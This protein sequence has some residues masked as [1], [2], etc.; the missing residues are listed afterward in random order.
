ML[1]LMLLSRMSTELIVHLREQH[2]IT[3]RLHPKAI[4]LNRFYRI[5]SKQTTVKIFT[6]CLRIDIEYKTLGIQWNTTSK[7]VVGQLLRR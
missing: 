7:D 1:T 6:A 2:R 4:I 3:Q 5:Q